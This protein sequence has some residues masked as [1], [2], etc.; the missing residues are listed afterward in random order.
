MYFRKS[1]KQDLNA[2]Q[3]SPSGSE[4]FNSKGCLENLA[5]R[6]LQPAKQMKKD[7]RH[8][9]A[10]SKVLTI[11]AM[12]SYAKEKKNYNKPARYHNTVLLSFFHK[13]V[14]EHPDK[15]LMGDG[16]RQRNNQTWTSYLCHDLDKKEFD[17]KLGELGEAVKDECKPSKAQERRE[18]EAEMPSWFESPPKIIHIHTL[19]CHISM[20]FK[21]SKPVSLSRADGTHSMFHDRFLLTKKVNTLSPRAFKKIV[22]NLAPGQLRIPPSSFRN[23][24]HFFAEMILNPD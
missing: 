14:E 24:C 13:I 23:H 11:Q 2:P 12:T 8:I 22:N 17:I 3:K 10:A 19:N 9:M 15:K 18:G 4:L 6:I 5:N 7:L 16:E 1:F 21:E 20:N